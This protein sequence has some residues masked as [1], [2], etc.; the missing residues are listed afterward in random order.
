MFKKEL[1][2]KNKLKKIWNITIF[3]KTI[4]ISSL[5]FPWEMED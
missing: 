4:Q 5:N 3:G 2:S 1:V